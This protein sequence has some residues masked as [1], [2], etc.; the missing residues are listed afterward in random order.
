MNEN[1]TVI[2]YYP[3]GNQKLKLDLEAKRDKSQF[4]SMA[5]MIPYDNFVELQK[6][7]STYSKNTKILIYINEMPESGWETAI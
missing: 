7:L 5:M 6:S 4:L 2:L 1:D 3:S